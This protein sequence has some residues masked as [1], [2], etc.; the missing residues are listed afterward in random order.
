MVIY[1][2]IFISNAPRKNKV[3]FLITKKVIIPKPSEIY[4]SPERFFSS[5]FI[6]PISSE[7]SGVLR[8]LS[9]IFNLDL[10]LPASEGDESIP[11]TIAEGSYSFF[12]QQK[13]AKASL[14]TEVT[15][16]FE[17]RACSWSNDENA[18]ASLHGDSTIPIYPCSTE[19][20]CL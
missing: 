11:L 12:L 6:A 16:L 20:R 2:T 18:G 8:H 14:S 13:T 15:P 10:T 7:S 17:S 4:K 9:R 1:F 19:R 5:S 3:I